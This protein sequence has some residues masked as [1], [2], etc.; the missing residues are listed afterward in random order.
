MRVAAT[1]NVNG[2]AYPVELDPHTTL[3]RAVRE[4]VG[5]TPELVP[6]VRARLTAIDDGPSASA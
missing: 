3:L 1:L 5:L 4:H 6:L 2:I